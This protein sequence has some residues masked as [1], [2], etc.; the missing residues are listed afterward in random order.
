MRRARN[1]ALFIA[2][3]AACAYGGIAAYLY[4]TQDSI[5]LPQTVNHLPAA[6]SHKTAAFDEI[7]IPTPDGATLNGILY[8]KLAVSPT[9]LVIAFGGNAHDV[10][11]M[12][13]FLKKDVFPQVTTAV[14]GLSYRG[15]PNVLGTP[16]TGTPSQHALYTDSELIYDVL[17]RK[18]R[19]HC[20]YAIGYSLGTA[21]ATHLATA[22]PLCGV[23]LIAPPASV[24]RLAQAQYPWLPI[25]LLLKNPFPTED[26]IGTVTAPVTIVYTPT[27][28]LIPPAHITEVLHAAN[29]RAHI[30]KVTGST[31]G[32][33]LDN[34]ALPAILRRAVPPSATAPRPAPLS[35][36]QPLCRGANGCYNPAHI[37]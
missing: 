36:A 20:V 15:Y 8:H 26:I 4:A 7:A 21:V 2:A 12:A 34:P 27:D 32:T 16:S 6:P 3:V 25:R 13:A 33:I 23:V 22:R 37:V 11:G 19:P 9:T 1:L 29:P 14:A 24:R 28:G 17:T 35:A 10:V 5:I 18:F 31:H 30:I